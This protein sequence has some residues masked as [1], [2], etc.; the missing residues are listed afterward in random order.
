MLGVSGGRRGVRGA[1]GLLVG[2]PQA[3]PVGTVGVEGLDA[4][5]L[6]EVPAAGVQGDEA[7]GAGQ[8]EVRQPEVRTH[9]GP[10]SFVDA[11]DLEHV[12]RELGGERAE[13]ARAEQE[14]VRLQELGGCRVLGTPQGLAEQAE[15]R[16]GG[17]THQDRE[18]DEPHA[19]NPG[20]ELVG[21]VDVGV[22]VHDLHVADLEHGARGCCD[23]QCCAEADRCA[24]VAAVQGY[25]QGDE[26]DGG[27]GDGQVGG[28]V[29]HVVER[30]VPRQFVH[31][32][33]D[34]HLWCS[35]GVFH[36]VKGSSI[37]GLRRSCI[38]YNI[39]R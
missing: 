31:Q 24:L 33:A 39:I 22:R 10:A 18:A 23:E 19:G 26:Q 6:V 1:E 28:G 20:V 8:D 14:G 27:D 36:S 16:D 34:V 2:E 11:A 21:L 12:L 5:A 15:Q 30:V 29:E 38:F 17:Q 25:A 3:S 9:R 4:D 32:I 7:E 35:F 13:Q 37:A